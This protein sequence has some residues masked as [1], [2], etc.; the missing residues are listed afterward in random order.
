MI[1]LSMAERMST[2]KALSYVGVCGFD[3]P[4]YC[5]AFIHGFAH[6]DAVPVVILQIIGNHISFREKCKHGKA[7]FCL[8][9]VPL[10]N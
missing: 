8:I 9:L 10:S 5:R 3:N 4:G 7:W 1:L 6:D 2:R